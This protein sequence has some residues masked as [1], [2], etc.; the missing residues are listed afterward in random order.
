MILVDTS[1]LINY[2]KGNE[3]IKTG[4]FEEILK[5]KLPY[6]ISSY[7]YTELLQG[8]RDESE[9]DALKEYL[10]T[11]TV[12]FLPEIIETYEEAAGLYYELRRRGITPRGTVDILIMLT[13]LKNDLL[14]LHD[15]GDFDLFAEKIRELRVLNVL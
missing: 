3:S 13:A 10:S 2:L 14:L 6:G 9:F 7:T 1:V 8:A 4:I 12:Y 11:Q 15:D 5:R